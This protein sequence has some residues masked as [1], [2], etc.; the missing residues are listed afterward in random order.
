MAQLDLA[1]W[2]DIAKRGEIPLVL[3]RHGQT[4]HNA[5][6]RFVGCSNPPLDETGLQQA[7]S[8]GEALRDLPLGGLYASPLQ[9][10]RQTAAP[11]GTPLILDGIKELDQG[12]LEGKR[13]EDVGE[14]LADFFMA[15]AKDP[16]GVRVPGGETMDECQERACA[17]L[18]GLVQAHEPGPPVVVLTHQMVLSVVLLRALGLPLRHW[19]L[20]NRQN[21]AVDLL[22]L[23]PDGSLSVH[24]LNR[25]E[26]LSPTHP[27]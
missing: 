3:I 18:S 25:T 21:T 26:H 6:R 16:T 15:W 27:S 13:F 19:R 20:L 22:G 14:D 5:E 10:T 12:E 23:R 24:E 8:L 4:R 9:R 11:L 1:Q 7:Q 2:Q 17:A